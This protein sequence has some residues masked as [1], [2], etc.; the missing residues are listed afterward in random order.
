MDSEDLKEFFEKYKYYI[1]SILLLIF[2]SQTFSEMAKVNYTVQAAIPIET[3]TVESLKEDAEFKIT[4]ITDTYD[5]NGKLSYT[6]SFRIVG[7]SKEI[8]CNIPVDYFEKLNKDAIYTG[9]IEVGYVKEIYQYILDNSENKF[10]TIEEAV[11]SNPYKKE[12]L[13]VEF[14]FS[15]YIESEFTTKEDIKSEYEKLYNINQDKVT[16]TDKKEEASA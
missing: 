2:L 16:D 13:G 15:K 4:S 1:F 9:V 8:I 11:N 10:K 3:V 12:I 6:V 5:K 7:F 14:M